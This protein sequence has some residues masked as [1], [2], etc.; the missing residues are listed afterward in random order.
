MKTNPPPIA[1]NLPADFPD[2]CLAI[3]D[4]AP[5]SIVTVE[6]DSHLVR[7]ANPAFCCLVDMPLAEVIG[8]P[9]DELM[10]EKDAC[11]KMIDRVLQTDRPESYTEHDPAHP[12]KLFWSYTVWPVLATAGVAN[13]LIQIAESVKAHKNTI[14]M[15]E[16]LMLG[17][18]RQH[19]LT[20]AAE[21]LN[22]Q[23]REEMD[24]RRRAEERL[25]EHEQRY[26]ALFTS[27]PMGVFVCDQ[28]GVIQQYNPRA[29][30][31]WGKEPETW[32]KTPCGSVKMWLPD[33]AMVPDAEHPVLKV[34]QTGIPKRDV[35]MY[36]ERPDGSRLPILVN[37]SVLKDGQGQ[38]TGAITSFMDITERK[39]TEALREQLLVSERAARAEVEQAGRA[40]DEFLALLAHELR[41]PLNAILGWAQLLREDSREASDLEKGLLTIERSA[42]AQAELIEDLLDISRIVSGKFRLDAE[43]I[44]LTEVLDIALETVRPSAAAKGIRITIET[45]PSVKRMTGDPARLKQVF[46]NLF[47]NAVK[48]TPSGGAVNLTANRIDDFIEIRISDTGLGISASFLPLMFERYTQADGSTTRRSGGLGLGLS[49]CKNIVELHGGEISVESPGEGQGATFIVRLPW[50]DNA[51]AAV[52]GGQTDSDSEA[53]NFMD[54]QVLVVDD[55][56]VVCDLFRRMFEKQA[57]SVKVAQSVADAILLIQENY[58]DLLISDIGMPDRDGYDFIREVR[59]SQFSSRTSPA[60]AVT[61]FARPEDRDRALK[62]GY[63]LHVAKPVNG[64]EFMTSVVKLLRERSA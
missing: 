33:G 55:D 54:L 39:E 28:E 22:G 11:F 56:P 30:E 34:M 26:R 59:Q 47:S 7:Y 8:K 51:Q 32:T 61:V 40:K 29:V 20:E 48:F 35:E 60:I 6:G 58:F 50:V 41:T 36:M 46:W 62:A 9:F 12:H 19:E 18:V 52:P 10:P 21:K 16:A 4:H 31:L 27:S 45:E 53:A 64:N 57:A 49:I 23:L 3:N 38:V 13:I 24:V 43:T 25:A 42:R 17:S 2:L 37:F 44:S 15:N 14:A 1:G 5:L 63:D